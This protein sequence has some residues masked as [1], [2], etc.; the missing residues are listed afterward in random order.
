AG[1]AAGVLGLWADRRGLGP[2]LLLVVPRHAGAARR[3]QRRGTAADPLRAAFV[4]DRPVRDRPSS[5]PVGRTAAQPL[6]VGAVR[7]RRWR[8]FRLVLLPNLAAP[9]SR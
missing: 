4:A 2:G 9:L 3:L 1:G 6:Y 8:Q 7:G 5:T